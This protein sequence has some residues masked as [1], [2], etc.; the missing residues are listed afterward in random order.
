MGDDKV[1]VKEAL[2]KLYGLQ[3]KNHKLDEWREFCKWIETLPYSELIT[4]LPTLLSDKEIE[5]ALNSSY[6]ERM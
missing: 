3:R 5:D 2:E 6:N 4:G 1:S